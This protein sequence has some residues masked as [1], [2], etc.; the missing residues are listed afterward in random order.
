MILIPQV[1]DAA[2]PVER[3]V[4]RESSVVATGVYDRR[5]AGSV[6]YSSNGVSRRHFGPWI[7]DTE[8][9]DGSGE[10]IFL[11]DGSV[12]RRGSDSEYRKN[13]D[14]GQRCETVGNVTVCK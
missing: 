8:R 11:E 9:A 6:E 1:A 7:Y 4:E 12:I 3:E 10:L 13:P 2:L 5:P 14:G